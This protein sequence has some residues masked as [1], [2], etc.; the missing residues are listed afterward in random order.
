M[1]IST[2]TVTS[3]NQITIPVDFARKL[4]IKKGNKLI[5]SESNGVI[6]MQKHSELLDKYQG[7]LKVPQHL[8]GK[9]L[10]EAILEAKEKRFAKKYDLLCR[11]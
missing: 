1:L 3:K 5:I 10:D 7:F 9:N 8:R 4:N 11:Y 2:I 6:S